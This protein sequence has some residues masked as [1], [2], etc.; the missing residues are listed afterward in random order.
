MYLD[1]KNPSTCPTRRVVSSMP[2]HSTPRR[3]SYPSLAVALLLAA[4]AARA[5]GHGHGDGTDRAPV[6][7]NP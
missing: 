5:Q 3:F 4:P 1:R 7:V 2:H 6:A